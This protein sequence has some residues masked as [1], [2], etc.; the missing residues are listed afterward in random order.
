MTVI[1]AL[2]EIIV[3]LIIAGVIWWAIQQLLP[4]LPLPDPFRRI[5]NVLLVVVLVLIA[6]WV[7]VGLLGLFGGSIGHLT[8]HGSLAVMAPG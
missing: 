3:V 6:L 1:M 8:L 2:L 7:I 4:L 5:V